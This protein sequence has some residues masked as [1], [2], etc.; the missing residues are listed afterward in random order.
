[1]EYESL[2]KYAEQRN[3]VRFT[4]SGCTLVSLGSEHSRLGEVLDVSLGGLAFRCISGE[5][6]STRIGTLDVYCEDGLRLAKIPFQ[7]VWDS[8]VSDPPPFSYITTRRYGVRFGDLSQDQQ[9]SLR[10]LIQNYT[11][12]DPEN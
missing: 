12:E 10:L 5:E 9:S 11:T 7:T 3:S 2:E 4:A 6:P 8:E 1:M